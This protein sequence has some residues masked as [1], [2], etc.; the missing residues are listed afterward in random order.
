MSKILVTATNYSIYCKKAKD[1]L[2]HH[3]HEI[4]ENTFGR[5]LTFEEISNV[6]SDIDGVIAGVD[7]WNEDVFKIAP[8]LKII[9]RFGIG[10][11]NIDLA[12]AKRYGI[13]VTN[14]RGSTNAVAELT[15]GLILG[16]LRKIPGLDTSTRKGYW[17]RFVGYE[18]AGKKVGLI[19]F[20]HIGQSV[21]KKLKA[22]DVELYAY[23]KYPDENK[24]KE[25][26]VSLVSF[27]EIIENCDIISLHIP[28]TKET[29]HALGQKE[30]EKMKD[31]AFLINTARGAI[32]DEKALYTAL[33]A[34]KLAGAGIDVYEKEPADAQ[35]PL[36]EL[37]NIV[38]TPHTGAETYE[39][40]EKVSIITAKA[41]IDYF[42]GKK[43]ENILV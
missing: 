30:F 7:T 40:I 5:P 16:L 4:I 37:E 12:A 3:G 29:H 1:L 26:G 20:G 11:D 10:V 19:G 8:K 32:I 39:T 24:A 15:I 25:L 14:A 6:I 42:D 38:V 35:N 18:L 22:F 33:K 2:E 36:F 34:G 23:D 21:A 27:D 43:P 17:E 41:I 28:S 31:G 9:A 13:T